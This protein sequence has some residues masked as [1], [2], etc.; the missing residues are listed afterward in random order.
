MDDYVDKDGENPQ[1]HALLGEEVGVL[2][3]PCSFGELGIV[4]GLR[5]ASVA[6]A[7]QVQAAKLCKM[8]VG[9]S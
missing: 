6:T 9:V 1:L 7:S 2:R 8:L 4:R 5:S 3:A